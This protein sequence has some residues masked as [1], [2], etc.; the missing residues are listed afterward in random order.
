MKVKT[1]TKDHSLRVRSVSQD[2]AICLHRI[3][4]KV[5]INHSKPK[6]KC[7][8]DQIHLS[9]SNVFA[10]TEAS[11]LQN[12]TESKLYNTLA[13]RVSVN[14]VLIYMRRNKKCGSWS[15]EKNSDYK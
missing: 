11:T 13:K 4:E 5:G 9:A 14:Q 10:E 3:G 7:L 1:Q 12:K 15:T 8:P 6:I 2:L